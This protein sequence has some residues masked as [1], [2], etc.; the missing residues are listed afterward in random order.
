MR[1]ALVTAHGRPPEML[2]RD[3]PVASDGDVLVE[4]TAAPIT[5]LDVLCASGTS[6]FGPPA[7][8][9]VPGVQGVGR[10]VDDPTSRVWFTTDAGMKPGDGSLAERAAVASLRTLRLR[11]D[12]P[13]TVVAA[14]GLSAVA[15]YGALRRGRVAAGDRVLVLGAGGVVGQV[16]VQLAR[17]VG[18]GQVAAATRGEQSVARARDLGADVVVDTSSGL[19]QPLQQRLADA[20]P[21]GVDLVI[22]PVW[23]AIAQA[24]AGVLAPGGRLVNLGDAAGATAV[25]PSSLVRSRSLDILGYTN[26]SVSWPDQVA[27]L[28]EVLAM[29]ADG[30]LRVEPDVVAWDDAPAG[31]A[32]Q[33]AG[34]S[35]RRVV[36]DVTTAR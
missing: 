11:H 29:V 26:L 18:A 14:L 15:A 36:V 25:L 17:I 2:E 24:A 28:D 19:E 20:L 23:G 8:P 12:V 13:D 27:M 10:L 33:A 9:Y 32:R 34:G 3:E 31:W 7:L 30:R 6:Y 22:D 35:S 4:V 21:D 1:A 5:P 16:A